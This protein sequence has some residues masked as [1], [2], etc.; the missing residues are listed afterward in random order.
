MTGAERVTPIASK[1]NASFL[2][3]RNLFPVRAG[4]EASRGNAVD[5]L[6]HLAGHECR[7]RELLGTQRS[8]DAENMT[9]DGDG[10]GRCAAAGRYI[11][12]GRRALFVASMV[13][14]GG[15]GTTSPLLAPGRRPVSS[16]RTGPVPDGRQ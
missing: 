1:S 15:M 4:I 13:I 10:H 9:V 5:S 2:S 12:A 14:M 16:G 8:T 7:K 11:D 6:A 3:K